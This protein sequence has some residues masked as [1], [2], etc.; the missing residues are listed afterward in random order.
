MCCV[1]TSRESLYR[2]TVLKE[3]MGKS[4]KGTVLFTYEGTEAKRCQAIYSLSQPKPEK[5]YASS[6]HLSNTMSK[7]NDQIHTIEFPQ[8]SCSI[9]SSIQAV[10]TEVYPY[11]FIFLGS[12][13]KEKNEY[14]NIYSGDEMNYCVIVEKNYLF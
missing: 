8:L 11:P 14:L 13:L 9:N 3:I 4:A 6:S 1:D 10:H 2:S 7:Y 5:A 12:I